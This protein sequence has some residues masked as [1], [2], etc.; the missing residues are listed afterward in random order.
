MVSCHGLPT[1]TQWWKNWNPHSGFKYS[2]LLSC[3][4]LKKLPTA[5]IKK[6]TVFYFVFRSVGET[7]PCTIS[8]H[9]YREILQTIFEGSVR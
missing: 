4:T 6:K 5:Q 3:P 1:K 9:A 7:I 8:M 2:Y